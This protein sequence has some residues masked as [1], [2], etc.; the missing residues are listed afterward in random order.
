MGSDAGFGIGGQGFF[1]SSDAWGMR[2][3]G[4]DAGFGIGGK[5]FFDSSDAIVNLCILA[6]RPSAEPCHT[7]SFNQRKMAAMFQASLSPR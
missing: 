1:A 3:M 4:S 6:F 2:S 7:P 5:E